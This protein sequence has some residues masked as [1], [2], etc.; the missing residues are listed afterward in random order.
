MKKGWKVTLAAVGVVAVFGL[1]LL[2]GSEALAL[3]VDPGTGGGR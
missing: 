2:T 1:G 3:W